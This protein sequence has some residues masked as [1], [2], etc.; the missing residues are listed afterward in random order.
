MLHAAQNRFNRFSDNSQRFRVGAR[1]RR[2]IA[3]F[4]THSGVHAFAFSALFGRVMENF[5]NPYGWLL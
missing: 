4:V 5:L 3:A 1:V 2:S